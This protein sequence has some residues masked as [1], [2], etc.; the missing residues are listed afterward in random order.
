MS[1]STLVNQSWHKHVNES[2]LTCKWAMAHL[3]RSHMCAITHSLPRINA[4]V[5]CTTVVHCS[6]NTRAVHTCVWLLQCIHVCDFCSAYMCVT[7]AVHT[8]VWLLQCIHVCDFCSALLLA[9]THCINI[10]HLLSRKCIALVHQCTTHSAT[11]SAART[12]KGVMYP[13]YTCKRVMAPT[14]TC[15]GVTART[16]A[17]KGTMA[18]THT[19]T[20]KWVMAHTHTHVQEVTGHMCM[21]IRINGMVSGFLMYLMA[22]SVSL[23]VCLSHTPLPSRSL[24]LS[25]FLPRSLSP[26]L[27]HM[28]D[29]KNQLNGVCV[30]DVPHHQVS[31]SVAVRCSALQC[32]AVCCIKNQWNCVWVLD[33]PYDSV[34]VS[35]SLSFSLSHPTPSLSLS[36]SLLPFL[37]PSSRCVSWLGLCVCVCVCV[38]VCVSFSLSLSLTPA[39]SL[40]INGVVRGCSMCLIA[41]SCSVLQCIAMCCNDNEWC[42]GARCVS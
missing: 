29:N 13:T 1:H 34:S 32:V 37:S 7:S 11:R 41:W 30:L 24:S 26:S 16:R 4:H 8:C 5:Q 15:K 35:I 31:L 39:A 17:S 20:C 28:H 19:H 10:L 22:R 18:H 14:Y 27:S 21:A 40:Q 3:S 42:E 6:S 9:S 36:P 33:V 23:C 12:S 38:Y 2:W 25:P